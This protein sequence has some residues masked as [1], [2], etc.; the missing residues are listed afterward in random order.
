MSSISCTYSNDFS[1]SQESA[2]SISP[3][4]DK[5]FKTIKDWSFDLQCNGSKYDGVS[6][7]AKKG[8]LTIVGLKAGVFLSFNV[9]Y[10]EQAQKACERFSDAVKKYIGNS[11]S[12][13][14]WKIL[15]YEKL[16]AEPLGSIDVWI[17]NT[18]PNATVE[19]K[20][21]QEDYCLLIERKSGIGIQKYHPEPSH[22]RAFRSVN[23]FL[24][25]FFGNESRLKEPQS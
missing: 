14:L 3:Q 24:H 25:I 7:S 16:F 22:E 12:I 13:K 23:K 1:N 10:V 18:F 11:D 21:L 17:A 19:V 4:R 8:A 5:K 2:F 9:T 6:I 15:P 20:K